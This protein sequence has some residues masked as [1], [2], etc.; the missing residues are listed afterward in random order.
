[1]TDES[2][3][4]GEFSLRVRVVHDGERFTECA[5][6]TD[7]GAEIPFWVMMVVAEY[8]THL[9]ATHSKAGYEKALDL[10]RAGAMTYR[11]RDPGGA[12]PFPD[13]GP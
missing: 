2:S 6:A 1:M 3:P 10:I 4:G 5:I 11:H 8:F 12:A 13:Q 7:G 9:T